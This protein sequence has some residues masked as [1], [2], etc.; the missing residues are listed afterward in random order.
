MT[1][2]ILLFA[3]LTLVTLSVYG[4]ADPSFRRNQ[5]SALLINP[6]QAGANAADEVSIIAGKS[7]IVLLVHHKLFLLWGTF[8]CLKIW[9]L[10][11]LVTMINLVQFRPIEPH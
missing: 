8:V 4:Q 11:P 5:F 7:L 3:L 2:N 9:G 10:A 6:A 1:R